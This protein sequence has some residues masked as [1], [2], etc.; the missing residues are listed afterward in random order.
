MF[1]FGGDGDASEVQFNAR[2]TCHG[3]V[4]FDAEWI[5]RRC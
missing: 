1:G 2:D 4:E 5:D 3:S